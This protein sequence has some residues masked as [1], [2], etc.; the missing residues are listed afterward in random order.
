MDVIFGTRHI[1]LVLLIT[2]LSHFLVTNLTAGARSQKYKS[3]TNQTRVLTQ[4]RLTLCTQCIYIKFA[5]FHQK[6]NRKEN[7]PRAIK[8]DMFYIS[9]FKVVPKS[10]GSAK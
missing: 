6:T 10:I 9:K 7:N 2:F 3:R 4:F 1:Y 8:N 5:S